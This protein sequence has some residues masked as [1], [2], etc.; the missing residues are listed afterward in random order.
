MADVNRNLG[1]QFTQLPM[2]VPAHMLMDDHDRGVGV[3]AGKGTFPTVGK[4][5][6]NDL[7]EDVYSSEGGVE[8]VPEAWDRKRDE[9]DYSGLT[10]SIETEG[11][12]KPVRLYGGTTWRELGT[13]TDGHHRVAAANDLNPNMEVPVSWRKQPT[14]GQSPGDPD[15]SWSF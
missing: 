8:T 2:F 7:E 10:D 4:F 15:Q 1:S 9:A 11:I 13:I 6:E 3:M 12:R 14:I 5:L